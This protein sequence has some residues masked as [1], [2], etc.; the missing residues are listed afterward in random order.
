MGC[1]SCCR[2]TPMPKTQLYFP[3]SELEQLHKI[4]RSR[5]KSVAA[6]VRE[7]VR[8]VLLAPE[9]RG[10]VALWDGKP[11]RPSTDHDSIYDE[12]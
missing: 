8:T 3:D 4:A 6:L 2:V 5:R 7:A 11:R 12:P 10:P 9:P 1:Q